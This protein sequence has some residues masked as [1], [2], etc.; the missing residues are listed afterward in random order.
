MKL[1]QLEMFIFL[2]ENLPSHNVEIEGNKIVGKR[3]INS[4]SFAS[5][6][7]T[8]LKNGMYSVKAT[9]GRTIRY[10]N[11]L[12]LFNLMG[13]FSYFTD[14]KNARELLEVSN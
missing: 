10:D 8:F 5:F 6:K 9:R 2:K 7:I 13:H 12:D 3:L 14:H 11:V 1:S 4:R